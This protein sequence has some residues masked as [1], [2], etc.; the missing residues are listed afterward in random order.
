VGVVFHII[1][2]GGGAG[3][4]RATRYISERE[5]DANREG[6]GA[7]PLFSEDSDGLTYRKA[8]RLL[9]PE[10]GQPDKND[11]IHFSVM[12][13]EEEFDKLGA[14]EREKQERF[15]EVIRE[16]MKGMA[17]ELNVERLIWVA[18]IHR[19]SQNPHAHVVMLKDAVERVTG[20]E[21]RIGRIRKELL[22]HKEIEDGKARIVPGK[23]GERFLAALQRQQ[24]LYLGRD[25]ERE[26]ALQA[27]EQLVQR[28][29]GRQEPGTRR[30]GEDSPANR[31]RDDAGAPE[32]QG[33]GRD[34]RS[35]GDLDRQRIAASWNADKPA[36]EDDLH[37]YRIDLGK[38]L[39]LSIRLAFTQVWYDRSVDHGET[40][41]FNVL[42]QST[43]E[44]RKISELD[45]RRRAAARATR[46]SQGDRVLR[47]HAIE[48]DLSRHN[49]TLQQLAE[50]REAKIAALE[51]DIAGLGSKL[52]RADKTVL[53]AWQT[54]EEENRTPLLDRQTLSELQEQ[55]VKLNLPEQVSE[56]E[57]VRMTLAREHQAPARTDEEA[58]KLAAQLN[59]ARADLMARDARLE[60]FEASVHLTTYEIHDERWSLGSIDKQIARRHDDAKLIPKR[61]ERLDLRS[62]ARL[63]YSSAAREQAAHDVE[64]LSSVRSEIVREIERRHEP[65]IADRNLADEM[66]DLLE[67]IQRAEQ[68]TRTRE[69]KSV[70]EPSYEPHQM[71]ALEASA[72]TLRDSTLLKEVHHWEKTAGKNDSDT[73]WEGRAVA[74]EIMSGLAVEETKERLERFL[75]SK[76]VASLHLGNHRTGTLR[77]VQARTLTDYLANAILDTREQREH[78]QAVKLAA[79]EHHGRLVSEFERAGDYHSAAREMASEAKG[80][81][82]GFTDK[83]KINLEIYAE[84]Q[85]DP[86]RRDQY[87][88]LAR[89]E[90]RSQEREIAASRS[91]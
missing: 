69:G 37:R 33:Q 64:H 10:S 90:G 44:E 83:E 67:G 13:E 62:L 14:D 61:A 82:P 68:E 57:N 18:G 76:R 19:N 17:E 7:R 27:W 16:G 58:G 60:R 31:G 55:A 45:V 84:R 4:S 21:R 56:L 1:S 25:R 11:L 34:Q 49:E 80:R 66:L 15:R 9:D 78:R 52:S 87:L 41:R 70:A 91:R 8:D 38:R 88:E 35:R 51:K 54:P 85:G 32:R 5:R 50:I 43:A 30:E 24:A 89:G 72:E 3:A 74:R 28:T 59:V 73:N 46:I 47:D 65:L 42:D 23:I 77:E 81:E 75:E 86:T 29:Q 12:V 2:T 26:R 79:R 6:P 20:R 53:T 39:E 48:A 40:Y 36:P 22:P 63:N 71:R